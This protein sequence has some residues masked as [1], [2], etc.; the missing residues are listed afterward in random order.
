MGRHGLIS[1][2]IRSPSHDRIW[3]PE[4]S[5]LP[6]FRVEGERLLVS[7]VRN[8]RWLTAERFEGGWEDRSYELS[9]LE[10]VWFVLT[11]FSTHWRGPAHTLLSFQFGESDFLSI[12]IEARR[13]RG[14]QY[15]MLK[16]LFRHFEL[17]YVAGDE[18]DVIG[19]RAVYRSDQVYLYPTRV[20]PDGARALLLSMAESANRLREIP[21]FYNTFTNNCLTRIVRHVNAVAPRRLPRWSPRLMMP[22]FSDTLAWRLGLLDVEG[23]LEAARK[24][25]F[26]NDRARLAIDEPDFSLRIREP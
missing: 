1:G 17:I 9:D 15:G 8:F 6:V 5:V 16:G 21:E 22:G 26:V 3:A 11:P 23:S 25:W 24:R 2:L 19:L 20:S 7:G 10:R 18:R 12:S 13:E 14:E 4:Q